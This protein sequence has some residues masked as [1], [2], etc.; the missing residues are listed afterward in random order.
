MAKTTIVIEVEYPDDML[1]FTI[2]H[3]HKAHPELY[4]EGA[5]HPTATDAELALNGWL[6]AMMG[7]LEAA[8]SNAPNPIMVDGAC[9]VIEAINTVGAR[10]FD[11]AAKLTVTNGEKH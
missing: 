10:N 3:V 1:D 7:R 9:Y 11:I 2:E 8:A 4:E 5:Q 6:A